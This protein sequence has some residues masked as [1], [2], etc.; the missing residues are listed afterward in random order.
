MKP[1]T[2]RFALASRGVESI[3]SGILLLGYSIVLSLFM[4]AVI[5]INGS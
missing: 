5:F 3:H 4:A 2:T 1:G